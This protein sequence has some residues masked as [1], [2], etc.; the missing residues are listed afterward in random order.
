[1]PIYSIT[2]KITTTKN[3][4]RDKPPGHFE[5]PCRTRFPLEAHPLPL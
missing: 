5:A 4:A 2:S 3:P 1:E